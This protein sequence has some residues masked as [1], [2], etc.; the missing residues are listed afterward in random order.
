M[1]HCII[2]S[3]QLTREVDTGLI[4]MVCEE[5]WEAREEIRG[6]SA[7]LQ[8]PAMFSNHTKE[9]VPGYFWCP[10]IQFHLISF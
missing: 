3:D 4:L 6:S 1:G 5:W 2:I 8:R 10:K 7:S 9:W